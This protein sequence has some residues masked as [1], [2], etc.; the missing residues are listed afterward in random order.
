M[1]TSPSSLR[2]VPSQYRF[3]DRLHI[4]V[5]APPWIAVPPPGYGGIEAVVDLLCEGLVGRGHDVR[6]FAAPGS[7]SPA[8]V[9]PLL[10]APHPDAIGASQYESDHVAGAWEEIESAASEGRP[11]DVL[12]DHSG[13]TALAMADRIA[14]PVVH[15]IHGPFDRETARFYQRH[16]RKA[17]LVAISRSQ[18][19]TAPVGARIAAVV[20]NPIA[21]ERWPFR[22]RKQDYVLL[23]GRMTPVKGAHRAVKAAQLAGRRLVLAGPVQ[24]GQETYFSEQVEPHVDGRRVQYV[25]EIGGAAKQELFAGAAALLMP[26]RWREPF[27][28]VMIEALA[29]GTPVIAFPEGAAAE[30]VIDGENGLL[31]SDE[32][33]MAQAI[34]E[35]GSIDP[36][37]CR[38]SVADRYAVSVTIAG[39]EQMYHHAITV[40]HG[41]ETRLRR[42]PTPPSRPSVRV[43]GE[44]WQRSRGRDRAREDAISR[45]GANGAM[46]VEMDTTAP[47]RLAAP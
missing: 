7:R 10:D 15:T 23:V 13:F 17:Q 12:H 34:S 24:P 39:Y 25:G 21:L 9:H 36:A 29:C 19:A 1:T 42:L 3:K 26:V 45:A 37:R 47:R 11:F 38:A 6:L 16:G 27:G 14:V 35:V 32:A 22:A 2:L 20:P 33:Q 30:I 41:R 43:V 18:A 31:V 44:H 46:R 8:R 40:A 5:L 4:A 28:M